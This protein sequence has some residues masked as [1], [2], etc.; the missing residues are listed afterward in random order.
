MIVREPGRDRWV[1]V[2]QAVIRNP[3]LS[4]RAKGILALLLSMPDGWHTNSEWIARNATEGRDAVR[5]ALRELEHAGHMLKH[6]AQ[7]SH[8]RWYTRWIVYEQPVREPVYRPVD[9]NFTE[10]GKPV[11]GFPGA[12]RN[13]YKEVSTHKA[14]DMIQE[15]HLDVCTT[16]DGTGWMTTPPGAAD[17][18]M[19]CVDCRGAGLHGTVH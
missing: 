19:Q 9:S 15:P 13:T 7:D 17:A 3:N 16:C 4:Y 5:A 6:K 14:T 11:V 1:V 8:G 12:I 18:L 10:D 2:D